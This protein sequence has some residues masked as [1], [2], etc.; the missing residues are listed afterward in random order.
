MYLDRAPV[1]GSGQAVSQNA[2]KSTMALSTYKL[3]SYCGRT[4][5]RNDG[6]CENTFFFRLEVN[7]RTRTQELTYTCDLCSMSNIQDSRQHYRRSDHQARVQQLRD[8]GHWH[9]SE[10]P[11]RHERVVALHGRTSRLVG[12][13]ASLDIECVEAMSS[14]RGCLFDERLVKIERKL[15]AFEFL[16]RITLLELAVWKFTCLDS[17]PT[18][19]PAINMVQIIEW[20]KEGWK[21]HKAEQRRASAIGVVVRG[22]LP[23]L[24]RP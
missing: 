7:P 22:V 11:K 2:N 12:K 6:D 15:D 8:F 14:D 16:D 1:S 19:G 24:A 21:E 9:F 4:P 17:F 20:C 23:F 5:G 18:D 13:G 3:K 10:L